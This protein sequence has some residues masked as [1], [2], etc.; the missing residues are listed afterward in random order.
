MPFHLRNNG[1]QRAISPTA[2][3]TFTRL[4]QFDPVP[5]TR[6]LC[7]CNR[8]VSN[9]AANVVVYKKHISNDFMAF[10]QYPRS[11]QRSLIPSS[12]SYV[13]EYGAR[14]IWHYI[15]TCGPPTSIDCAHA[16]NPARLACRKL[17]VPISA[18]KVDGLTTDINVLGIRMNTVSQ[19]L[20]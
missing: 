18:H 13:T 15:N 9:D 6:A 12:G 5:R 19:M 1:S 3:A 8:T 2:C 4:H 7:T 10:D 14:V 11:S 20:I 17:G 16:L